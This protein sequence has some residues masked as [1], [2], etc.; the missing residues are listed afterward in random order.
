MDLPILN[1]HEQALWHQ[2]LDQLN[3]HNLYCACRQCGYEWVD[4][5]M[6]VVCS[7]CGSSQVQIIPCWQFPDD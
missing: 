4:S 7:Q 5:Q 3:R 2:T 6:N 1:E